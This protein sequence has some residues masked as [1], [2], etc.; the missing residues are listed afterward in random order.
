M[1]II[2]LLDIYLEY[3]NKSM[4]CVITKDV[5]TAIVSNFLP[6]YIRI[7]SWDNLKD[8]EGFEYKWGFPQCAGAV[9]GIH[10]LP[11]NRHSLKY[12]PLA[13]T[14]N[15]FSGSIKYM[16][17]QIFCLQNVCMQ[18]Y[19]SPHYLSLFCSLPLN[20]SLDR[21]C[22][23]SCSYPCSAT[24][25]FVLF[26]FLVSLLKLF[27]FWLHRPVLLVPSFHPRWLLKL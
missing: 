15:K 27:H 4:V 18:M 14:L 8:V 3:I 24:F 25:F 9:D 22:C 7:P 1:Q 17:E 11:H 5:C 12:K 26:C 16:T 10:S 21:H 23:Q 6:K 13:S 2:A 19:K 20:L